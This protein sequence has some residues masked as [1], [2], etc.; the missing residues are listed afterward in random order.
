VAA[1]ALGRLVKLVHKTSLE[2]PGLYRLGLC[3]NQVS[4]ANLLLP[5]INKPIRYGMNGTV[6]LDGLE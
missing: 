6:L 3:G 1:H 5:I 4:A 2:M